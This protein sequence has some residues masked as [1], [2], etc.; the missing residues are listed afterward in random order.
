MKKFLSI[1]AGVSLASVIGLA[2]IALADEKDDPKTDENTPAPV[3]NYNSSK[4]NTSG[5]AMP[6]DGDE[7]DTPQGSGDPMKGLLGGKGKPCKP[8]DVPFGGT[9]NT[10]GDDGGEGDDKALAKDYNTT[11]SNTIPAVKTGGDDGDGDDDPKKK[12]KEKD[13]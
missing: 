7:D 11:R 2:N 6:D 1:A 9:V 5:V 8:C 12:K 10:G 3:K 4:S 13:K